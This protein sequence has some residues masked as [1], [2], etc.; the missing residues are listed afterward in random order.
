[1]TGKIKGYFDYRRDGLGPVA[2]TE[3][4]VLDALE[5][6][7]ENS[8][9]PFDTYLKKMK[10]FFAFRDGKC[11]ERVYNAICDLDDPNPQEDTMAW[12]P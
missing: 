10:S 1:M 4:G 2:D 9:C 5:G 12:H 8:G 7:L 6:I 11:C 3:E